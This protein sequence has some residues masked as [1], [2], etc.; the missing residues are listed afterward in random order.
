[1][2][3]VEPE[4]GTKL[5]YLS[6]K[7]LR[8]FLADPFVALVVGLP[9][10]FV[11]NLVSSWVYARLKRQPKTDDVVNLVIE[12]DEN[13]R[14]VR[15]DHKGKPLGDEQFRTLLA[16]MQERAREYENSLKA[17]P[18]EP[19]RPYPIFLEHTAKI[20]GWAKRVFTDTNGLQVEGVRIID[21]ETWA[22][23]EGDDLTGLSMGGIICRS[24]CSICGQDYTECNHLTGHE[25][26]GQECVV[27]IDDILLADLSLVKE[28]IQPRA[29]IKRQGG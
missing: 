20:V 14:K 6:E 24:T 19:S 4:N 28:P 11:V 3:T 23:I 18:P 5:S 21:E 13:G 8:E 2:V 10:A 17:I 22:R 1:V 29:R 27:R 9:L 16:S 12:F 7:G 15:Y 25:Y 26:G